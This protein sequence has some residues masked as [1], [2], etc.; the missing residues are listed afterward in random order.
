MLNLLVF[1]FSAMGDVALVAPVLLGMRTRPDIQITIVTRPKFSLF[2]ENMARVTVVAADIDKTYNGMTGLYQLYRLLTKNDIQYDAIIDLHDSLRT[3]ILGV[4]FKINTIFTPKNSPQFIVF[5]KGRREKKALIKQKTQAELAHTTARYTAAFAQIGI[6]ISLPETPVFQFLPKKTS[7]NVATSRKK[8][9]IAPF[10][11]HTTKE[12]PFA[13]VNELISLLIAQNNDIEI[14]L[15]G[16]GKQELEKLMSL[17]QLFPENTALAVGNAS[18]KAEIER[19]QTL[20]IMLCMDSSNMH[21]AALSGVKTLSIWGSTHPNAG[22]SA[23]GTGHQTIQIPSSEL[24][25]RPCAIF[26]DKPCARGDHACMQRIEA[27]TVCK[28]LST[29]IA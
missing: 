7:E 15:F 18:F 17:H 22:F 27:A 12:W 28:A 9:G 19:M 14:W 5:N 16:G 10:A 2:F 4:F 1:R 21:L 26:G 13:K 20:D 29:S 11:K 6:E 24:P 23:Y 25:C 3:R 8:I